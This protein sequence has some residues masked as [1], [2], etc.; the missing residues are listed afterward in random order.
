MVGDARRRAAG[1][2][3]DASRRGSCGT[4]ERRARCAPALSR[5]GGFEVRASRHGLLARGRHMS[6]DWATSQL[7]FEPTCSSHHPVERQRVL[8]HDG[9]D[10]EQ[11]YGAVV[12]AWQRCECWRC[13]NAM[14]WMPIGKPN[15][16][17][18]SRQAHGSRRGGGVKAVKTES[19]R[20]DGVSAIG[21][22]TD[23][24]PRLPAAN[25]LVPSAT[26]SYATDSTGSK[27]SCGSGAR[28]RR[29]GGLEA[30]PRL[31][32]EDLG[33]RRLLRD[34]GD[35]PKCSAAHRAFGPYVEGSLVILHLLQWMRFS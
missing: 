5:G 31:A 4:T 34:R 15:A 11:V 14:G 21:R 2:G 17:R 26:S 32:I 29:R 13:V 27:S 16:F 35:E 8:D 18:K 28:A 19:G 24:S 10:H 22:R 20:M 3:G 33:D 6:H 7:S 23:A 30:S 12:D 1:A 9:A 25:T